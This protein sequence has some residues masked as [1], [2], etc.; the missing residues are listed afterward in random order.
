M[1]GHEPQ[2]P[3]TVF[4]YGAPGLKFG[5]GARHEPP[6]TWPSS[7]PAACCW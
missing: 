4:T 7:T 6:T 2:R 5:A 3:E 1:W